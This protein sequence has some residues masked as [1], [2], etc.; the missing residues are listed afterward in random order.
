MRQKHGW[1]QL[2]SLLSWSV[3]HLHFL[4]T[5][6]E[7]DL[8]FMSHRQC[9]PWGELHT[10]MTRDYYLTRGTFLRLQ[11]HQWKK[12]FQGRSYF[13]SRN[14]IGLHPSHIIRPV[15][16]SWAT[17]DDPSHFSPMGKVFSPLTYKLFVHYAK[18]SHPYE[19]KG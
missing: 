16:P 2:V 13:Q 3:L 5:A 1:K 10:T 9:V 7:T 12:Q 17:I 6:Q 19:K 14:W 4:I 11:P 18:L 8:C 15:L